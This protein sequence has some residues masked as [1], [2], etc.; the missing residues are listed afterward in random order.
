[1]GKNKEKG[2]KIKNVFHIAGKNLKAKNKAKPVTTKLKKINIV[3]EEKVRTV[4]KT[5]KD[6]QKELAHFSKRPPLEPLPNHL[7]SQCSEGQTVSV[8]EAIRLMAQ[9]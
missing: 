4:N 3:K 1:M 7:I 9:L 6:I 5:F 8:D 2:Q